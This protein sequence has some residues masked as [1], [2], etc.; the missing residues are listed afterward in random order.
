MALTAPSQGAVICP[1]NPAVVAADASAS[2]EISVAT[3]ASFSASPA[4]CCTS[5]SAAGPIR[6]KV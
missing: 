5:I 6:T 1:N 3:R 4:I 2:G